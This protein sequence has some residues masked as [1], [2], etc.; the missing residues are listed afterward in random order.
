MSPNTPNLKTVHQFIAE[1]P[2]FT[3]GGIRA[4]IFNEERNGLKT[5]G[6]I[7]RI[8]RKILI[9]V[10]KFFDWVESQNNN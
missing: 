6:A 4:Y 8:G 3:L 7:K 9:D 5:S 1:N 2:A 10:E